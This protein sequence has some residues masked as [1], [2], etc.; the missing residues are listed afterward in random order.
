MMSQ[1]SPHCQI[2]KLEKLWKMSNEKNLMKVAP[3][4]M[5]E[6]FKKPAK[7]SGFE[8]LQWQFLVV[9]KYSTALI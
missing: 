4:C 2:L 1:I 3:R 7:V 8:S 9:N 6:W 5:D